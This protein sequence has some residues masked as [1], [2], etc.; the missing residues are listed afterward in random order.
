[1]DLG[2]EAAVGELLRQRGWRKAFTVEEM[3]DKWAWLVE[4]VE[5]GY[6]DMV[7]EYVN[8]LY[9]RNWLH[10]AWLL[11]NDHPI[12]AWTPRIKDLDD[13]FRLTTDYDDGYALGH[14]HRL[15]A[16]DQWWW[17]RR[18]RILAGELGDS[19]RSIVN[20]L[21]SGSRA[22]DVTRTRPR[23]AIRDGSAPV[24]PR[25]TDV[26]DSKGWAD[27]ASGSMFLDE[28][29]EYLGGLLPIV[30][31]TGSVVDFSGDH[32]EVVRV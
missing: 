16:L 29:G 3:V 24:L 31:L 21:G 11:L 8:D 32:R 10:Q 22:Q 30:D 28:F 23:R 26:E 15:P 25:A 6:A 18:P 2:N 19:L 17:R 27:S 20:R 5:N 9:S 4:E 1:M 14:F 12:I 13:R 7:E